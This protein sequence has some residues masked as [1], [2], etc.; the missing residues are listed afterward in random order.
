MS[1]SKKHNRTNNFA[2]QTEAS[3]K[4][5][6]AMDGNI[7]NDLALAENLSRVREKMLVVDDAALPGQEE[8][9]KQRF[10]AIDADIRNA[11][12]LAHNQLHARN[13]MVIA[14]NATPAATAA[15]AA[16]KAKLASGVA[17]KVIAS[18]DLANSYSNSDVDV[19]EDLDDDEVQIIEQ[20]NVP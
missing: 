8:A 4:R 5:F 1:A 7:R 14:D 11:I 10:R 18:I 3:L 6:R 16:A 9:R 2:V 20:R 15:T 19:V 17:G 13:T 12:T